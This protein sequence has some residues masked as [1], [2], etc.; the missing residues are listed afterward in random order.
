MV[1]AVDSGYSELKV[2]KFP[3]L[4]YAVAHTAI[5]SYA[6]NRPLKN[7]GSLFGPLDFLPIHGVGSSW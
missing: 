6:S 1:L 2:R 7:V 4:W 5:V 3:I